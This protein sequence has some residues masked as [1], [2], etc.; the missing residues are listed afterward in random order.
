MINTRRQ[1]GMALVLVIWM[2]AGLTLLVAGITSMTRIDVRLSRLHLERAQQ[3]ALMQGFI[4][5]HMRDLS[6]AREAGE[7]DFSSTFSSTF[8]FED[9]QA[10]LTSLPISGL[11]NLNR[12]SEELLLALFQ[13]GLSLSSE[14]ATAYLHRFLDWRSG[15]Q[16]TQRLLGATEDDYIEAGLTHLPRGKPLA[17]QEDLLQ[18]LGI[19][20]D[21]Y[22]ALKDLTS[23]MPSSSFGVNPWVAPEE[24]LL[25][26]AEGNTEN[27]ERFLAVRDAETPQEPV[28]THSFF[29]SEFISSSGTRNFRVDITLTQSQTQKTSH[30]RAWIE[31]GFVFQSALGVPWKVI[32]LE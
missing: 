14:D 17:V 10:E 6:L 21:D 3:H 29:R 9:Y 31:T 32:T 18:I 20:F 1:T 15:D 28:D 30:H 8:T 19:S 7:I 27:V 16:T 24:V 25:I 11:I 22:E 4:N 2:I 5:L 12:A 13:Y 23:V 26:L